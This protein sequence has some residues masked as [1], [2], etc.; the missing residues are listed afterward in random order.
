[1][2]PITTLLLIALPFLLFNQDNRYVIFENFR[3]GFIDGKGEVIIKPRFRNV[4]HFSHGLAPAREEAYWGFIDT[5]GRWAIEPRYDY[6][7]PFVEEL[8]RVGRN[9]QECWV[10]KDG[11]EWNTNVWS[12]RKLDQYGVLQQ[13][14]GG[15]LLL[16][17]DGKELKLPP[18][19]N[20]GWKKGPYI[21]IERVTT[22]SNG[23]RSIQY[24]VIDTSG[25]VAV[26]FGKF[27][28][29]WPF[30][31]GQA[32]A[33]RYDTTTGYTDYHL[34]DTAGEAIRAIGRP[35]GQLLNI[36]PGPDGRLFFATYQNEKGQFCRNLLNR[37]G[38]W[39]LERDTTI[40]IQPLGHGLAAIRYRDT[41]G[42]WLANEQGLC[43]TEAPLQQL[44]PFSQAANSTYLYGREASGSWVR[45]DTNGL[46]SPAPGLRA[47]DTIEGAQLYSLYSGNLATF[48]IKKKGEP[49]RIGLL[50]AEKGVL[51]P[52][53]YSQVLPQYTEGAPHN[54]PTVIA[55]KKGREIS[56]IREDGKVIWQSGQLPAKK[57]LPYDADGRVPMTYEV[58]CT[59]KMRWWMRPFVGKA[60]FLR[61]W[62]FKWPF[63]EKY[64][65]YNLYLMNDGPDTLVLSARNMG[66]LS[67]HLE[68][69]DEQGEWRRIDRCVGCD[70]VAL[71]AVKRLPP[72]H[73]WAFRVPKMQGA[74]QT[75]LR[76]V[77]TY[78]FPEE[79]TPPKADT[80][81]DG[82]PVRYPV[83]LRG[84]RKLYSRTFRGG[85]NPAQFHPEYRL[86]EPGPFIREWMVVD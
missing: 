74:I 4:G 67:I 18:G 16:S 21:G 70:V 39:L 34:I 45:F 5:L 22:L 76:Y 47:L 63:Q 3:Y 13:E 85:V 17:L 19:D 25:Q 2:K 58:R 48:G 42:V 27:R 26:P 12:R 54:T 28:K 52:P 11:V 53:V 82:Q 50:N 46:K 75:K 78:S 79:V 9:G 62:Y 71:N 20:L 81:P 6:A 66:Q 84:E 51:L 24:G 36:S 8:A 15:G 35:G 57:L 60:R 83:K 80:L 55:V 59:Y 44:R 43:C 10:D 33:S 37:Q 61:A 49:A 30:F 31:Q 64:R 86:W 69:Q 40:D 41:G 65:G 7:S 32:L 1:M 68:A 38:E 14:E 23:L 56:Y 29:V 73:F 72:G 77:A